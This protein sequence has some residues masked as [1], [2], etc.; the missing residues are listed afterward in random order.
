[1]NG[2]IEVSDMCMTLGIKHDIVWFEVTAAPINDQG[3]SL[4]KNLTDE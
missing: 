4:Q 1:M 2:N 3:I